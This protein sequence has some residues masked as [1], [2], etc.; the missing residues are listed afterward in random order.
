MAYIGGGEWIYGSG[1]L[2]DA[3]N[4]ATQRQISIRCAE[5]LLYRAW[6]RAGIEGVKSVASEYGVNYAVNNLGYPVLY[7][8]ETIEGASATSAP[9]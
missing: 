1:Q 7:S 9:V 4:A 6:E 8:V 3:I 2:A 5:D